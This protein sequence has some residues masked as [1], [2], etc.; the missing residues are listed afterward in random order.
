MK[1]SIES[2]VRGRHI[3]H[4]NKAIIRV[5]GIETKAK[6]QSLYG[7]KVV[8]TTRS[9]KTISGVITRYH[10]NKGLVQARFNKGLPGQAIGKEVVLK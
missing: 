6:A 10:G 7:K 8:Y 1:A 5:Q 2:Y 3:I 9:G 4:P